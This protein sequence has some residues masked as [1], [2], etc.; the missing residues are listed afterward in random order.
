MTNHISDRLKTLGIDLPPPGPP[1]AAYVMAATTGNIVFLSGHIAKKHGKPWVGKL[2]LDMDTE[3]GKAA[4]KSI[5]ID[6]ISA[7]IIGLV[8]SLALRKTSLAAID[9][10][11]PPVDEKETLGD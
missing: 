11:Y 5:A 4:A 2:G 8:L 10:R 1:A 6:L 3:T 9:R 7:V